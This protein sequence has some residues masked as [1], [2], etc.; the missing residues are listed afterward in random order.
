MIGRIPIQDIQP[1]VDCGQWPAKAAAGET[2]EIS[3]TVF[4]EGHDA[5]AAGVVLI[6]PDGAPGRMLPMR[7]AG[8]GTDRWSV[9]VSLPTEGLWQFR[10]EAWS[11]PIA[12]WTHDAGIKIPRNLDADLMC[13][14]GARLFERAAKG[15][16]AADCRVAAEAGGTC[17]HRA[18]LLALAARLRDDAV[19]PRARFA[20]TQLPETA[21][22][23]AAHPLRDLLTRSGRQRVRVDRRRALFGSWYEFFPRSEGAVV[24]QE[25]VAPKS[26]TFGTAARRLPAIAQMGFDVVYLPPI[27]PIGAQFRKGRN[28]TLTPDQY[29]PGSPWAIGSEQGGHD[30]IHPDLGTIEDFDEFVAKARELGMEIALD[31]ALQCSP[32][33]PWVKE[34]P[35]WFNIRADG[36]IAYAENPPKKY[37]D[38][39][40]LN[41]DKDPEGIYAEV[42]RV[43]RHWMDHGVRIF[44]VDNP[45]TK[46]VRF[47]ERLISDIN[48]TDPD[49]LFLAEAF[50]RPAMM[51]TL[52]KVGFHQ[53][54]TYF[55]WRN[56]KQ[57]F[58]EY[59]WELS[60]ETSHFLRPNLFVN[61]PD[62]LHEYLQ[63]G[64]VPA[65]RIRAVLAALT[66]PTWGV[67]SG[68][69]LAENVPVRPGSE[70]YL[71]SEKYQYRPRDWAAAEREGRSLAPFITQ[72]NLLRRAHPALQELRNLRFHNVDQPDVICFSKR[73]PGAYDTASR[74]HGLG[75][76]VLAVVNLDPYNTHEATVRLDM[77]AL[78]LDWHADFVV[79]DQLSGESYRWGQANYV[80]LDPHVQPAHI[81][82][83][84]HGSAL[85]P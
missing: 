2:F 56:H 12:T 1:V 28:N 39:Y 65:F 43:V 85:R 19:D 37:Q 34:H 82:T 33:H 55:T 62:I 22:L 50:T 52:G 84:R 10:V 8:P 78:G 47:W 14:E 64:G 70:E 46:P 45:H 20:V 36:T 60:H 13:E 51:R 81:L 77:P 63:H 7:E 80:R 18:A 74:R 27:H 32:D 68:Y 24:G 57:E 53:S 66:A 42:R 23:I 79:D 11:D 76:V 5:V 69:E 4:R 75:D 29:D 67:Y 44:R 59:L 48:A 16:R 15:V 71:D 26:G 30:A 40:P 61:T 9:E 41:F 73:L 83:L 25:G 49:V 6:D 58:E 31:L 38:I 17:G 72:L 54:Y 35:E 3:A 21:E